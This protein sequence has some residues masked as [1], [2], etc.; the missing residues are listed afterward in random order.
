MPHTHKHEIGPGLVSFW[1]D[2]GA[3][4]AV[5]K[6]PPKTDSMFDQLAMQNADI[7]RMQGL[8]FVHCVNDWEPY[9]LRTASI[10]SVATVLLSDYFL[11]PA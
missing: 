1:A 2:P 3:I 8:I 9:G 11:L 10:V 5:W 7:Y 6:Y 4:A